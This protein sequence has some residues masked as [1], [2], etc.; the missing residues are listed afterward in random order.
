[1]RNILYLGLDP[2]R[3]GHQGRLYHYP[4]IAIEPFSLDVPEV[5]KG[6][7]SFSAYSHLIFTS[8]SAVAI[9]ASFI[10]KLGIP[11]SNG[12]QHVLAVGK[13]TASSLAEHGFTVSGIAKE[14]RAEG[15]IALLEA[16]DLTNAFIFYP[17][18]A[19]S[20][21]VIENYLTQSQIRYYSCPVYTTKCIHPLPQPNL[22][23]FDEIVFTS[24]STVDAFINI[25]GSIPLEKTITAIGPITEQYLK[26]HY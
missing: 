20:R 2:H 18:S 10:K 11:P 1:M 4:V 12:S 16:Q 8:Q 3:F 13:A 24:P 26:K 7:E 5:K 9:T 22:A 23:D 25:Y 21:P 6:F 19:L 15:V 17:R 14:E